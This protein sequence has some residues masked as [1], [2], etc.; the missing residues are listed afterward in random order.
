MDGVLV[1]LSFDLLPSL[2]C[3]CTTADI[4]CTFYYLNYLLDYIIDKEPLVNKFISVPKD[5]GKS[6]SGN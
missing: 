3:G 6:V 2:V 4:L 1:P 5:K